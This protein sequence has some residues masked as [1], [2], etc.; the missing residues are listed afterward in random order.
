MKGPLPKS[1]ST[2]VEF[3]TMYWTCPRC[4]EDM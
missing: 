2:M 4:G 1:I 3:S